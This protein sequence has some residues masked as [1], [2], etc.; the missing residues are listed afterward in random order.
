MK[1]LL[2]LI[3][4]M[5]SMSTYTAISRVCAQAFSRSVTRPVMSYAAAA[6]NLYKTTPNQTSLQQLLT[7]LS[8]NKGEVCSQLS[9]L[10][11]PL[12]T[13]SNKIAHQKLYAL[14]LQTLANDKQKLQSIINQHALAT[15]IDQSMLPAII[16][17]QA[18]TLSKWKNSVVSAMQKI[19]PINYFKPTPAP[20]L[21]QELQSLAA[22]TEAVAP[23]VWPL[24]QVVES[25]KKRITDPVLLDATLHRLSVDKK[26]LLQK[27]IDEQIAQNQYAH[28]HAIYKG[29]QHSKHWLKRYYQDGQPRPIRS[30]AY[31][32][33]TS[34]Y[35]LLSNVST[36]SGEVCSKIALVKTPLDTINNKIAHQKLYDIVLQTLAADK[37][38]L[39]SIINQQ[40][41]N[42]GIVS[43]QLPKITT[44]APSVL[45]Q[46]KNFTT[47]ASQ[48]VNPLNYFKPT[49][50]PTLYQELQKL[51][52]HTGAVAPSVWPLKQV[53]ENLK[54]RITDPALLDATLKRLSV[55]K[56]G[57]LQKLIDEQIAHNQY[58]HEH[59][60]YKG[61]EH[62]KHWLKRYQEGMEYQHAT[63][64]N[65]L[66]P[67]S[68]I[69]PHEV[70]ILPPT[71]SVTPYNNINKT[72]D[73]EINLADTL[74]T[75][76]PSRLLGEP[77]KLLTTGNHHERAYK[78][79][80]AEHDVLHRFAS[81]PII[82]EPQKL[83]EAGNLPKLSYNQA[84]NALN[85]ETNRLNHIAQQPVV[86]NSQIK[87][88]G[89]FNPAQPSALQIIPEPQKLLTEGNL[90]KLSYNQAFNALNNEHNQL[91]HIAQ[92]PV[93]PNSQI[94]QSGEF[95]P[96][97]PSALQIIPE[98]QK[99]LTEG[100]LPKISY[101]QA[102]NALNTERDLLHQVAPQNIIHPSEIEIISAPAPI[103][104]HNSTTETIT[105]DIH[106]PE[107][108]TPEPTQRS[109]VL[110]ALVV[111][112]AGAGSAYAYSQL[113]DDQ[114]EQPTR[115]LLV[116]GLA[117]TGVAAAI[118]VYKY[119]H[120]KQ[121]DKAKEPSDKTE[122]NDS[123]NITR[124]I[125]VQEVAPQQDN[126]APFD[127]FYSNHQTIG[128]NS[129]L[130]QNIHHHGFS[131][132]DV[133]NSNMLQP[134][135]KAQIV[136]MM[137]QKK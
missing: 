77:T 87:Q 71:S 27:L 70:T 119:L 107:P 101:N 56:K 105:H 33:P 23:S 36:H 80:N 61:L 58:A 129:Q 69:H 92:Q 65:A 88:S 90:P 20:T 103:I 31:Q 118:A 134:E 10:K 91:R 84:Q 26:G 8:L 128:I 124:E 117:A 102:Y 47:K 79:F 11:T 46:L 113:Q 100:N 81:Y 72:H 49:P 22:H 30:K 39:Q 29:L 17:A 66:V 16:T 114:P 64:A 45:T 63:T 25:L 1:K 76:T 96:A 3:C 108:F 116:P 24:K 136:S 38:K 12:T 42:N 51:A 75:S 68:V 112:G 34:M 97:Q 48:A 130:A 67:Q 120:P 15:G 133:Y 28:E 5:L 59:A 126:T 54:K 41:L 40:S 18:S 43:S 82:P 55:D 83:L 104:P 52:A 109:I 106:I 86:P 9:L 98:P 13:I 125:C 6:R 121:D 89:E 95:N 132:A 62:S 37:P 19:N 60:I 35:E 110:P 99:L 111:T 21:Y 74:P 131:M 7:N 73:Y 2:T 53:L 135:Q 85:A 32:H 123:E 137:H 14:V 127:A 115:S 94:K 44:P 122:E 4:I 57:L 78:A 93:V 50:A